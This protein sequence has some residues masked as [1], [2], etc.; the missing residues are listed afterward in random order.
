MVKIIV[1]SDS[2]N[3]Q[4]PVT[5]LLESIPR[6]PMQEK[7]SSKTNGLTEQRKLIS[8]AGRN[9]YSE[10]ILI[11]AYIG[12]ED[13]TRKLKTLKAVTAQKCQNF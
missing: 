9:N 10:Q 5:T 4:I 3:I 8:R 12:S 1:V 7:P 13:K 6:Q 11:F 2:T